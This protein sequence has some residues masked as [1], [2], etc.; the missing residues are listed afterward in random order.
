MTAIRCE[1][2]ATIFSRRRPPAA[3]DE[4]QLGINLVSAVDR[5]IEFGK[6]IQRRDRD[7]ARLRLG[8]R[9]L[10]CRHAE[11]VET[12]G[13]FVADE[14]DEMARSCARA[15]P[16]PHAGLNETERALR[17]LPLP[18]IA[19]RARPHGLRSPFSGLRAPQ[20]LMPSLDSPNRTSL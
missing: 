3:F 4:P 19:V 9:R 11:D 14:I 2:A 6:L 1:A 12:G 20:T 17:R 18:P 7:A 16:E 15:E 13:D 10:R 8:S 5:Q